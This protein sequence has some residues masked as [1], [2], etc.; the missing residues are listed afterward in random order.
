VAQGPFA[1]I[2]IMI[3]THA[4]VEEPLC[5]DSRAWSLVFE[6]LPTRGVWVCG[7]VQKPGG[8]DAYQVPKGPRVVRRGSH[9]QVA[10]F[11]SFHGYGGKPGI[12]RS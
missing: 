3:I 7:Y 11:H 4:L 1:A 9:G 5:Q 8:H 10:G 6:N 2:V 12:V